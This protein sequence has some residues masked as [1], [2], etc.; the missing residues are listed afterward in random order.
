M[1]GMHTSITMLLDAGKNRDAGAWVRLARAYEPLI[2]KWIRQLGVVSSDVADLTQEVLL[3]LASDLENFNHNG[4]IGAF[5]N[6]LRTIAVNRCRRYWTA[7][8]RRVDTPDVEKQLDELADPQSELTRRWDLEHDQF[9][10]QQLLNDLQFFF[11]KRSIEVFHRVTLL[12]ESPADVARDFGL[13]TGHVYKIKFRVMR[14]LEEAA[15]ELDDDILP[16]PH[17]NLADKADGPDDKA[18]VA[19]TPNERRPE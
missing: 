14:K 17:F 7:K 8:G 2:A 16:R 13:T 12:S 18:A 4:R 1:A 10:L 11:D 19:R 6:W 9:V 3:A 15:S 5:R